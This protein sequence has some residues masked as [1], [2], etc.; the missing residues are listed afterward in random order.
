MFF[1][2]LSGESRTSRAQ[3]L[4]RADGFITMPLLNEIEVAGLT[5]QQVQQLLVGRLLHFVA[6]PEVTVSIEGKAHEH[7]NFS[8]L[9]SL[10]PFVQAVHPVIVAEQQGKCCNQPI[11]LRFQVRLPTLLKTQ[12]VNG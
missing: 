5:V 7:P 8:T 9:P 3:W 1:E 4:V 2:F 12:R 10:W 11:A 6:N